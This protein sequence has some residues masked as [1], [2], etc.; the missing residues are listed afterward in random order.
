MRRTLAFLMVLL[1]L[2]A[3][4]AAYIGGTV[5][6]EREQ[7]EIYER[8]I[9]GDSSLA[10]GLGISLLSEYSDHLFWNTSYTVGSAECDT[11]LEF[12][13]SPKQVLTPI[14]YDG[15]GIGVNYIYGVVTDTPI[16]ELSG[17]LRAYRELYEDTPV[18][19][20]LDRVVRMADYYD[21]YPI[22]VDISLPGT[23]W[24]AGVVF[25]F[26]DRADYPAEAEVW[27]KFNSFF[28]IPVN[29]ADYCTIGVTRD[30]RGQS[31][32]VASGHGVEPN[33]YSIS[34]Y[35]ASRCFFSIDIKYSDGRG[36]TNDV[37]TSLIP[38]GYGI[39]AFDYERVWD[40]PASSS[41]VIQTVYDPEKGTGVDADSLACV[42][43]L[44]RDVSVRGMAVSPDE[45]E[46]WLLTEEDGVS[47]F[48]VIDIESM[49]DIARISLGET[50]YY[51]FYPSGRHVV[52]YGGSYDDGRKIALVSMDD[53][54]RPSLVLNGDRCALPRY[55]YYDMS[56]SSKSS[57]DGKRLAILNYLYD[58]NGVMTCGF[59]LE[60]YTTDGGTYYGEY[61]CS[62]ARC[63]STNYNDNCNIARLEFS[64]P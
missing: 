63:D 44:S 64:E 24:S 57:F 50:E 30:E 34:T 35:T 39:Y 2:A 1:L 49:T 18:G 43:P 55:N 8:A 36:G 59:T 11:E 52:L 21:Y 42:Y 29:E 19:G 13:A 9:V 56:H 46:L 37:D 20:S 31:V 17:I 48:T 28:K 12:S 61:L 22:K 60:V 33:L 7:V 27:D 32:G 16:E 6:A 62:L 51:G 10:A 40:E 3:G 47:V 15:A 5:Y 23:Y 25:Q 38:G 54:G 4:S 41:G 45:R 53:S 58:E 26:K 14:S